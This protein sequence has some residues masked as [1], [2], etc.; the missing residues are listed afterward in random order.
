MGVPKQRGPGQRGGAG[1][2]RANRGTFRNSG[3]NVKPPSKI[4]GLIALALATGVAT[5]IIAGTAL[6][7]RHLG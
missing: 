7:V 1:G 3:G 5:P 6:A 4:C 2:Q